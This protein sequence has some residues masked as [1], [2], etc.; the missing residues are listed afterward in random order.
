MPAL[1]Q[2]IVALYGMKEMKEMEKMKAFHGDEAIKQKYL[3]RLKAHHKADE[4]IQGK[5]WKNG[6]GCAVGCTLDNY[7][8]AA[9]KDELDLPVWL[10]LLEDNIF[11]GL[12]AGEAQQFAVDFLEFIPTGADVDKVQWQLAQQRH[13][14][15]RDRILSSEPYAKQC[16]EAINL[17]IAYCDLQSKQ[18]SAKSAAEQAAFRSMTQE[19]VA[20]A[21][22]AAWAVARATKAWSARA[23]ARSAAES[24]ESAAESAWSV[25]IAES[26]SRSADSA[27]SAARSAYSSF[28]SAAE[29]AKAARYDHFRWEAKTLLE[30]LSN[31][32]QCLDDELLQSLC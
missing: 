19:T 22:E 32:P 13:T 10:A 7:S 11:E 31:A 26:A 8:H 12:P 28:L 18:E 29:S 1:K 27:A 14:R 20:R 30:L 24:A 15:D 9:Y 5:G 6:S 2:V 16:V 3:A 21:A 4:I 25:E 23:H 17:V